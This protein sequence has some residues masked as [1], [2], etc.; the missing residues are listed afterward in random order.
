MKVKH[1][2]IA[3]RPAGTICAEAEAV[4]RRL[5]VG[6][7]VGR[8]AAQLSFTDVRELGRVLTP[9]RLELLKAI[10]N[11]RPDSVRA[12][13]GLTGR[14]VKNVSQDIELLVALGLVDLKPEGKPRRPR[15]PR[16]GYEA[17]R[18]EVQL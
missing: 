7:K 1:L 12:L 3:I 16:V 11:H 17:S 8:Q 18:V 15:A 2:R 6:K 10:R 13:A 5:E 9:K 14:N 4:T